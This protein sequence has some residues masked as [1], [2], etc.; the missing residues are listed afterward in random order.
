MNPKIH[1]RVQKNPL[2]VSILSQINPIHNCPPCF[3]G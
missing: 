2:L 1:Y 3:S